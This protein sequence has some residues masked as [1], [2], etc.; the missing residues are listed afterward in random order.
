MGF[1]IMENFMDEIEVDSHPGEGTT[2]TIKKHLTKSK[3]LMQ[4]RRLANGCGGQRREK[5]NRI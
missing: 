3:A 1:T 2:I 5:S 4:L